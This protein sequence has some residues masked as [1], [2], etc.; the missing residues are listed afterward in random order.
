[1]DDPKGQ[2]SGGIIDL[3]RTLFPGFPTTIRDVPPV[4]R[5][6]ATTMESHGFHVCGWS[7]VEHIGTHVDAPLHFFPGGRSVT[8]LEVDELVVPARVMDFV[9][10][11]LEAPSRTVGIA[12][13]EAEEQRMGRI[14]QRSAVLLCTGW[15]RRPVDADGYLG[16]DGTAHRSP[17]WSAAA[18]EWLLA[19]RSI[20]ALGTDTSSIDPGDAD[21]AYA[22]HA[23]LGADRYAIEGLINLE[24]LLDRQSFHLVV[25]VMPWESGT[26]GP[27]RV[28]ALAG[29]LTAGA[30]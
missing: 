23:L 5:W 9:D 29:D 26:G 13:L 22:H 17:G 19:E 20:V 25:G 15:G 14:P 8:A 2:A 18:V 4:E 16:W 28:L 1:M 24:R 11:A 27:C 6:T 7:M 3:S 30:A 12:D 10:Q 21:E